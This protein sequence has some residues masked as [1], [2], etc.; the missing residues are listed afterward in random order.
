MAVEQTLQ[1]GPYLPKHF[2]QSYTEDEHYWKYTKGSTSGTIYYDLA[3][4]RQRVDKKNGKFDKFC[5]SIFWYKDTPCSQIVNEGKAYMYFP[6]KNHCCMCCDES[7]GCGIY[8]YDIMAD[9]EKVDD[10]IKDGV[11]YETWQKNGLQM[12]FI[13]ESKILVGYKEKY[14]DWNFDPNSLTIDFDTS[15]FDL[16]DICDPKKKCRL[17]SKCNNM[18][19]KQI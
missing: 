17:I 11:E 4:K 16:P 6:E 18:K 1:S 12:T 10:F 15:V 5:G 19:S 8:K 2:K 13:S 14:S 9:A 3:S 7:Q